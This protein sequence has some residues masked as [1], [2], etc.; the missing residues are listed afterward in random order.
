[1]VAG[2]AGDHAVGTRI[3]EGRELVHR[4]AE[5][6]RPRALEVLGLEY[7][8]PPDALAERPR[9]Q[10]RR[11]ADDPG[12]GLRGPAEVLGREGR[13]DQ[14]R[15]TIASISTSAPRGR[16]ATAIA[17]RAGGSDSK[18]DSYTSLTEVNDPMSVRYTVSF[19]ASPSVAP[20][21]SHTATRFSRHRPA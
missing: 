13:S 7:D 16:P 17:T 18:N 20:A 10:D 21:A 3:A 19:T 2:A 4:A 11:L 6:E 1:M 14:G 5:L 9:G 8:G 15:A 12:H